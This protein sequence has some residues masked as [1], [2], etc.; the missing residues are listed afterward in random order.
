MNERDR[1]LDRIAASIAVGP[2][3]RNRLVGIDGVDGAGKTMFADAL[4]CH[5]KAL[6]RPVLRAGIDGFHHPRAHRYRRGP[7]NPL[8][9]VED[10]FDEEGLRRHLL[11]PLRGST[12]GTVQLRRF[13]YR[14]DM[15]MVEELPVEPGT[16]LIFDGVFLHRPL[17]RDC[18][19]I[20]IFLDVPF[21]M[22]VP[23]MAARDGTP[24]DPDDDANRRY[25]DGQRHYLRTCEPQ[26][27][28]TLVIDNS[29]L[30]HPIVIADRMGRTGFSGIG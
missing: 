12:G 14:R 28:A 10:S 22:S 11:D 24:A 7:D 1:L 13:D 29:A 6:G 16:V 26:R 20:S 17:L 18:W 27:R 9:Y 5:V 21:T 25:V 8:G 4:S 30:D 19:D 2:A 3:A 15:P 23:R